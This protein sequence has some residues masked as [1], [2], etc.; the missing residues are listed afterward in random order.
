MPDEIPLAELT[1][2]WAHGW[3]V[4]RGTSPPVAM[5][6]GLMITIDRPRN[7]ARYV[8]DPYDWPTAAVLG[9]HLTAPGSEIKLV[10]TLN[11][12]REALPDD[13]TMYDPHHLM[14]AA[15]TRGGAE[16]PPSYTVR[17]VDDGAVLL[18][19]VHDSAGDVVSTARLATCGP[20][21]VIDRVRTRPAEQRRG[22][23]RAVMTML[24]NRALDAGLTTGLLSATT[25]GQALYAALGWT[26]RD[27]LAG[28]RRT[29]SAD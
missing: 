25:G 22:L 16:V 4:C 24:G 13:W 5:H 7:T 3:A 19:S 28:A 29:P 11:R 18:G 10:G 21:G 23:S 26:I 6:G 2:A 8:L 27:E 9:R 15:F 17:V 1:T 12:L 14:T 20:Y